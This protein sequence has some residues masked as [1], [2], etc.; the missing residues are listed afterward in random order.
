MR[1]FVVSFFILF[2]VVSSLTAQEND[3]EKK[4][5]LKTTNTSFGLS[6][7]NLTDNYLSPLPYSGIGLRI[8]S[9]T[10]KLLSPDSK[11]LS[12]MLRLKLEAGTT[13]NPPHT[14]SM[15]FL[16]L[17]GAWGMHY[18]FYP[19]TNLQILTG[20][21][22]DIDLGLKGNLRNV[23]NP[24]NMDLSTNLNLS[25]IIIYDIPTTKRTYRLQAAFDSPFIGCMFVPELGSS[26]YEIFSLKASGNFVHFSSFYNKL[27]LRQNY[28]VEIPFKNSTWRFGVGWDLLK[29]S[30]NDMIFKRNNLFVFFGYTREFFRF[31]KKNPAPQNFISY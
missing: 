25:A 27:G 12:T 30:T 1:N 21:L 20:G 28:S 15:L 11:T 22:W 13:T 16:G 31:S 4:Y 26:Y 23:N 19:V 24:F 29:Y 18:H 6:A 8:N 7:L 9:E 2:I 17:S 3:T 14:A 5:A 10:S